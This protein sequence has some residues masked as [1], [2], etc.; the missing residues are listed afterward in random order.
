M[1]TPKTRCPDCCPRRT[2]SS[3]ASLPRLLIA[4]LLLHW[5]SATRVR[6]EQFESD[7]DGP[8]VSWQ[9]RCREADVKLLVHERR[10]DAGHRVG[11]EFFRLKVLRDNVPLRFEHPVPAARVLDELTASL[12]VRSDQAGAV[13][14]L[15]VGFRGLTD[16]ET[17]APLS[18][19]ITGEAYNRP[20]EWQ[21]LKCQASDK[22]VNDKLRLLRAR[23]RMAIDPATMYVD[24]VILDCTLTTG[25]MQLLVDD[26]E[27]GPIVPAEVSPRTDRLVTPIGSQNAASNVSPLN[28]NSLNGDF[29]VTAN[30][31]GNTL[32]KATSVPVEFR[33]HRLRVEGRPFLPR[34]ARYQAERPDILAAAGFNVA[35][36]PDA[37]ETSVTMPLRRQGLWITA[38]PPFAKDSAGEPLESE[39]AS[40]LPFNSQSASVL[41]WMMGARLTA[42][43]RPRLQSWT[44]QV[45]DADRAFKRP[46]AA[47]VADDERLCSRHLDLLGISRHTM[48]SETSLL[49][50]RESLAQKRDRAWP[51]ALCWTWIQTEPT[52]ELMSLASL[53]GTTPQLEPEQIRAQVYAAL[54]V[55]CRGLGYWT[56][57]PL[58]GEGPA[59]RE[60][61][62]TLTQLNL[63]LG[64]LEPWLATGTSVQMIPFTVDAGSEARI[65]APTPTPSKGLFGGAAS[66]KKTAST[67]LDKQR[68]KE[69]TAALIRSEYGALLLPMWLEDRAQYVPGQMTA[70]NA[71]II[72]PGG[73]ETASAWEITTTGRLQYLTRE[74]VAG[75]IKIVLR[76][77][78]QTAAI[79]ITSDQNVVEQF[80][81]RIAAI[82]DKSAAACVELCQ[83]KLARTRQVDQQ[84]QQ[85][86][87]G[88]PA[89]KHLLN[90]AQQ[91][92]EQAASALRQ[93]QFP[94]ARQQSS[95]AMQLTRM[96]QRAHWDHAVKSMPSPVASPY[97]LTFQTLPAHWRL[98]RGQSS[99][100][101]PSLHGG[102]TENKLPSGDFEDFDTMIASGWRHEQRAIPGVQSVAEL[103]PSPKQGQYSLRLVARA[104]SAAAGKELSPALLSKIPVTVVSPPI[105]VHAGQ[106]VRISGW[107]KLPQPV[108]GSLDGATLHDSLLGKTGAWKIKPSRDWQQFEILR[109]VPESHELTVTIALHGLGELAIDDLQVTT[110]A[111]SNEVADT[112]LPNES[113]VKRRLLPSV[114][115]LS[116]WR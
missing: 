102:N 11:A 63:E 36:V 35:W 3:R 57:T 115:P 70:N 8:G 89:A 2:I 42:N 14:A 103:H 80:N 41:F 101:G 108:S 48:N 60:R 107:V 13:L 71:T 76:R 100:R 4:A 33:L 109:A 67:A 92:S 52:A 37:E 82:Q 116:G 19:V 49:D 96:L 114:V 77:F 65:S 97:A 90:E 87:A 29:P 81:Q 86:G 1:R 68:P 93:Q 51:G 84:L 47:D 66:P 62:L 6:A 91:Y 45:R 95:L 21:Q 43:D 17:G 30:G 94:S 113:P 20:G 46:L 22:A 32:G 5:C 73:G 7:F 38:T 28:G 110:F 9:A 18:D 55:G 72:V 44:N 74:T 106:V 12:W 10:R 64:L 27:F 78:D 53:A 26:L 39:D 111:L 69:L 31:T 83:L 98:M 58:D 50:Y 112:P 61:L 88:L 56:T 79:L 24:R 15:K 23:K 34:M 85:L 25:T 40:L 105:S 75:G 16:P 99:Q 54:S 59:A 104:D